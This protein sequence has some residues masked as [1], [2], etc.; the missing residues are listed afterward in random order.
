MTPATPAEARATSRATASRALG[1]ALL[2]ED[3]TQHELA[4]C[5]GVPAQK[6]QLWTDPK[7]AQAPYVADLRQMPRPVA[8]ALL[9][10][11][12]EAHHAIVVDQLVA[13]SALD[14]MGHLHRILKEGADVSVAYCAALADGVVDDVE[15]ERVISELREDIVAKQSLLEMLERGR[16][17][18]PRPYAV[19]GY[20]S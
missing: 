20:A 13:G 11:A 5:C 10:W 12:A 6:T 8:M 3:I 19:R 4:D 14:H 2:S 17:T 15:R 7:Q 1:R 18:K 9:S 16:V